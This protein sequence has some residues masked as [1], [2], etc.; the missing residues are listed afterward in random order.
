VYASG[1]TPDAADSEEKKVSTRGMVRPKTKARTLQE[2]QT[3]MRKANN[4]KVTPGK[5]ARREGELLLYELEP[6]EGATVGSAGQLP[7]PVHLG[8]L[9]IRSCDGKAVEEDKKVGVGE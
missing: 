7:N 5:V 3:G 9:S 4:V 2:L 8:G 6:V 1:E